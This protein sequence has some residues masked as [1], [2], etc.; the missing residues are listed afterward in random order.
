MATEC[1][2]LGKKNFIYFHFWSVGSFLFTLSSLWT[3]LR[4]PSLPNCSLIL[5]GFAAIFA[6]K[7]VSYLDKYAIAIHLEENVFDKSHKIESLRY[8]YILQVLVFVYTGVVSA[9]ATYS[10]FPHPSI[11][12]RFHSPIPLQL[13]TFVYAASAAVVVMLGRRIHQYLIAK[14]FS[15]RIAHHIKNHQTK[16]ILQKNWQEQRTTLDAP[17]LT[18]T[19]KY[20]VNVAFHTIRHFLNVGFWMIIPLWIFVAVPFFSFDSLTQMPLLYQVSMFITTIFGL[21]WIAKTFLHIGQYF[22]IGE[23]GFYWKGLFQE[24]TFG[25]QQ[26]DEIQIYDHQIVFQNHLTS[27]SFFCK[28]V[29][30]LDS[31]IEQLIRVMPLSITVIS[32]DG[33]KFLKKNLDHQYPNFEKKYCKIWT[34]QPKISE[35][36]SPKKEAGKKKKASRKK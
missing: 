4:P 3:S 20:K 24:K 2:K 14:N 28:D 35:T 29:V 10:L 22:E 21:A 9:V 6:W 18:K 17:K 11:L 13:P 8:W 12:D 34:N 16:T 33:W 31:L 32:R 26:L 25:W 30:K 19:T 36:V 15:G 7:W 1:T 23:D 27:W 5:F